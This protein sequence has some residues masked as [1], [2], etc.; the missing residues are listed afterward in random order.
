MN[1]YPLVIRLGPLTITGYG[2]LVVTGFLMAGWVMQ[3]ELRRRSLHDAYA[4]DIVVAAVLGGL[5]GAKLWYV[6]LHGPAALFSGAGL[7]WYGG[8]LGGVTAVALNSRWRKVPI[9]FTMELTAPALALGY[10]LGRVGCFLVQDDYGVPTNLPW[11]LKFP[12]GTPPS[13]AQNLA[14][15]F[16]VE[17]PPGAAPGEVLAVHPTQLYEV[18][19]MLAAFWVLWHLRQHRHAMGWLFGVYLSLA[20][21]ERL[22]IELL[23]AKD[24]R[25]LGPFTLA[26]ATSVALLLLGSVLVARWWRDDGVRLSPV[27]SALREEGQKGQKGQRARGRP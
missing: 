5:I 18:A 9:R 16:G 3:R 1:V 8:F 24:D 20:G 10:A 19:A 4:A 15:M 22:V 25:F 7:V 12:H 26:Q 14:A 17:I 13:T 27:P 23:R 11:G 2:L 6:A 21:A